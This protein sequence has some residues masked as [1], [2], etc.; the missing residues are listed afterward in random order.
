[1]MQKSHLDDDPALAPFKVDM[2]RLLA[3]TGKF[4]EAEALYLQ[5]LDII[6]KSYGPDHLYTSSVRSSLQELYT[7]Q[8]RYEE[9]QALVEKTNTAQEK[10]YDSN[11]PIHPKLVSGIPS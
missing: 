1:M 4:D 3:E 9:A 11:P 6:I 7:I 5:A 8:E 2:A 10:P